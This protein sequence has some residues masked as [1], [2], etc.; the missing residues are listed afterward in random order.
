MKT[1]FDLI[2]EGEDTKIS[3]SSWKPEAPP[4]L[5]RFSEIE[6]D[7]ETTGLSW[8]E[9]D[10]PVGI[11]IYYGDKAQY[12]PWGHRG[13]G[14]LD[15][16]VVKRWALTEL[17]G[18]R[19]TNLNMRFDVHMLREWGV[20]LEA[21][22]NVVSDVGHYAALL[23]DHRKSFS[24]E[25]ISQDYLGIG[26]VAG[27][28]GS[29]ISEY[30]AGEVAAYAEQ[31]VV[32][33]NKLR[34]AM[35]PLLDEQELQ[36]VRKL[37]DDV[38]YVVCEMEKNGYPIDLEL[39][40]KWIKSSQDTMNSYL[41]QLAKEVGFQCNPE[42]PKDQERVFKKY[43]LPVLYTAKGNPT[44]TDA[45]L[46]NFDHPVVMLIRRAGKL[47]SLRSKF[48]LNTKKNVDSK[49]I[50]RYAL[51]QLRTAKDEHADKGEA[52]TVTGRF[53]SSEITPGFGVNIQ[54]RSKPAKQRVSFGYSENDTSHDDE[55]FL[56][57]K[58]HIP[59][60][61]LCL[62]SDMDQAQYRIFASYAKNPK[63]IQAY[64]D[65]PKLSFHK[66]MHEI[67]RPYADLS[68][69]QQK[70]TNFSVLFGAGLTK[71][72]LML[73]H[74]TL[75]EFEKIRDMK[76]YN[77]PKL[78]KTKHVRA[79]Y[80]REVPEVKEMLEEASNL[81]KN[82]GYVKTYLGR[83][84][85]FPDGNRLHKAFNG[86]DQGTEADYMKTKLVELHA[87]RK[88][89]QF[90]LRV[91]N[92]DEVVGDI[93]DKEHAKMVDELLNKQSFPKLRVPLT[94]TTSIGPN[95]AECKDIG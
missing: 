2:H 93:P 12:I 90:L 3:S 38:I 80:D 44:F 65:N 5:D 69:G 33:V 63:I 17:K 11:A 68:Y 13:G 75:E 41:M 55:I 64:K 57:R 88:T 22:G 4:S 78:L 21:Q 53:S 54:Q 9:K 7:T 34:K 35:W 16:A 30:P 42:S 85:R 66:F 60:S 47:A 84:M 52:G 81:A 76:D 83:R 95:W 14:N 82:R 72:A 26:K 45:I 59:A 6:L 27:L 70:D 25:N 43:G 10:R 49:G 39:L 79:I 15:E 31:D 8:F 23:D 46:K 20:D 50:L 86:V 48:I 18:K 77:S 89:T 87:A 92:H 28:E 62:A 73:K 37:E 36:D 74:I 58:L 40:D 71:L 51:H 94:W 91:T 56:V 1:L 61:G 19:I 24:L 32:L 29:K 67:I